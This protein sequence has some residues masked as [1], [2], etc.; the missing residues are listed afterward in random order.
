LTSTAQNL[1]NSGANGSSQSFTVKYKANPGYLF[2]AGTYT[3]DVVYTATQ[4]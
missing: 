3:V 4:Q 1:I 2:G